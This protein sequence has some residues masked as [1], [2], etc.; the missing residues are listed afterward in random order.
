MSMHLLEKLKTVFVAEET[1]PGTPE[2]ATAL[3]AM[4]V[5]NFV[6]APEFEQIEQN[7][8]MGILG[9]PAYFKG[10]R[11]PIFTF[12]T[13]VRGA[14]DIS[15]AAPPQE[16]PLYKAAGMQEN[17]STGT[18]VTY[19]FTS[20]KAAWKWLTMQFFYG[21]AGVADYAITATGV[22]LTGVMRVASGEPVVIE[23]RAEGIFASIDT[24]DRWYE[25]AGAPSIN[26]TTLTTPTPPVAIG[27]SCIQIDSQDMVSNS[28]ELDFGNELSARR[29]IGCPAHGHEI[30][31]ITGRMPRGT[32]QCEIPN[33]DTEFDME[34]AIVSQD[35][36][37]LA[38]HVGSVVG[39]QFTIAADVQFLNL[40][41]SPTDNMS[42]WRV[43]FGLTGV[44]DD[45]FSL[46]FT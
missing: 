27:G 15:P 28:F 31:Y 5:H 33:P 17:I 41:E 8:Q 46:I 36:H 7:I 34:G 4:N 30:P 39:N 11:R 22:I 16:A 3:E 10:V 38:L 32:L 43:E 9:I 24:V 13:Y 19:T 37:E 21:D 45:E 6:Y 40:S 18:N 44:N 20:D 29:N 1:T 25:V 2:P 35:T 12:N 42:G 23:W 26:R 14:G